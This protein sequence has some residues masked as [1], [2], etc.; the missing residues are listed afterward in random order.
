MPVKLRRP[1]TRTTR[2]TDEAIQAFELCEEIAAAGL[3]EAWEDEGGRR[4]EYLTALQSLHGELS[5]RPWEASPVDVLDEG[6]CPW[7]GNLYAAS[8]PKA[9]ELRREL[10]TAIKRRR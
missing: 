5:L 4:R 9:Q 10:L 3:D 8:W 6:S 7:E 1:K 2:V